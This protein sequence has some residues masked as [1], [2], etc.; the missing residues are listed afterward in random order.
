MKKIKHIWKRIQEGRL[1]ELLDQLAWMG[2]Y[3]RKYW[4]LIGIYTFLMT[5][6][7]LLSLGS[8]VVSRDLVDAV[9][10]QNALNIA[11]VLALYIGTGVGQIF[12]NVI[13]SRI[14]LKISLK[15]Q[16]EIREDVFKQIMETDWESLSDYRTGDLLYRIN[17]DAGM[18]AN[19]ILTFIPT[20]ISV[21]ISFGSAF[22]IMV[23]NDP[24]M[25]V[26]ALMGA[27]ITLITSR[28]SM[29]KTRE[30]M[31][32]NQDFSSN[33]MSFDQETFNNLQMIKAFG[34]VPHFIESFHDVQQESMRI[35]LNQNKFQ[36][37]STIITSLVGQV[38]GY[39]CYGYALFR[40]WT[41]HISYGTMTMFV[42]M[43]GSLRGSFSSIVNLAPT[44]VR[45]CI[46]AGRIIEVITLPREKV[47]DDPKAKEILDASKTKGVYIEMNDVSF[48]YKE[49]KPVY[50]HASFYAK[51]GEIIGLLGPSGQG[52]TTTLNLFLGL[53][54]IR[55]GSL[56]VGNPAGEKMDVSSATR[57]LFSYIPQGNTLFS[58]SIADN[59]GMVKPGASEEEI[60]EA[61]KAAC[62]WEF[63]EDLEEGIHTH[64]RELGRRFS[65]GQKQR[66]SIA[67]AL[68]AKRPIMLLDEAT[69]ALDMATERKV[70]GSILQYDPL[71][72][73]IVA[74]HR[75]S[76]FSMCD[77]VYRIEQGTIREVDREEVN[78]FLEGKA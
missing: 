21:F 54:H 52:K 36:S 35:S 18:V 10:G 13:R 65:E 68:L 16:T 4:I 55:S 53:F 31:R 19:S 33:K 39:A 6:G 47:E 24:I 26:I 44:L 70:L 38:V 63:V 7:S 56:E 3:V 12:I 28:Y 46:N 22:W 2:I 77:R 62:A 67:R 37:M 30:Y 8:T 32:K 74:A 41:G 11:Y 64:V 34:L 42:G 23:Q 66:L 57:C 75:P 40:L 45:S 69:S 61:L 1:K 49:G 9:T 5:S 43:A 20:V 58:G 48:W 15:I 59:V 50:E 25:A 27:P 17:G 71:R 29:R 51:P 72:T 14:S 73:L 60:I 76:V 78:L